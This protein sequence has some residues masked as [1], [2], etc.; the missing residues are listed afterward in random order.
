MVF[1]FIPFFIGAGS[2]MGAIPSAGFIILPFF[3]GFFIEA[4]AAGASAGA[5]VWAKAGAMSAAAM[6]RE[7]N[8]MGSS[9]EC[10]GT[11]G[12]SDLGC[13]L[14]V[15]AGPGPR[16]AGTVSSPPTW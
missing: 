15:S 8:F 5:W 12:C 14:W 11:A 3:M 2:A 4:A 13:S 7:A 1:I 9:W 10:P 6:S 16:A